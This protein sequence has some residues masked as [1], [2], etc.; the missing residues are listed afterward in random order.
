MAPVLKV[1]RLRER[2]GERELV[3]EQI[4]WQSCVSPSA[5]DGIG[6][7]TLTNTMAVNASNIESFRNCTKINGDISL[8]ETSFIGWLSTLSVVK[9]RFDLTWRLKKSFRF[10]AASETRSSWSYNS[11]SIPANYDSNTFFP[12]LSL[13]VMRTIKSHPWIQISWSTS[14]QWRKS[15]VGNRLTWLGYCSSVRTCC[16]QL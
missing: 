13:P 10:T 8:I 11:W 6:V 16:S 15:Q 12:P 7:G 3:T 2:K 5:C 1:E 14:G 9:N 4:N